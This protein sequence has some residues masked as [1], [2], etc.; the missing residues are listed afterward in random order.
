MTS[1]TTLAAFAPRVYRD[2]R[3]IFLELPSGDTLKFPLTEGGMAK[4]LKFVPSIADQPGYLTGGRNIPERER[5]VRVAR[6]TAKARKA[7]VVDDIKGGSLTEIV[8][9]MKEKPE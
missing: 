9:N 1:R 7:T 4:A 8:R 5:P 6:K 3:T 2:A